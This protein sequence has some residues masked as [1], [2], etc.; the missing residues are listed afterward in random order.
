MFFFYL[1]RCLSILLQYLQ[2]EGGV[3]S[4]GLV[5]FSVSVFIRTLDLQAEQPLASVSVYNNPI[6]T[7]SQPVSLGVNKQTTFLN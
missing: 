3:F 5:H 1:Y 4:T 6:R 2:A 7:G